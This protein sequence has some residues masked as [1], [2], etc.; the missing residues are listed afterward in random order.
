MHCVQNRP[1]NRHYVFDYLYL[2]RSDGLDSITRYCP[3]TRPFFNLS[4]ERQVSRFHYEDYDSQNRIR[5]RT[6][7]SPLKSTS[8]RRFPSVRV[9]RATRQ[10]T[11]HPEPKSWRSRWTRDV[12]RTNK[13]YRGRYFRGRG[14]ILKNNCRTKKMTSGKQ[15]KKATMTN[16]VATE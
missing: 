12:N 2:K 15:K 16:D 8:H 5:F 13:M 3:L 1:L 7:S 10:I 4:N 9:E 11:L 6:C 14:F